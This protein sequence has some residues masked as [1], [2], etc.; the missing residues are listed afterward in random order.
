MPS[1]LAVEINSYT[2]VYPPAWKPA[3]DDWIVGTVLA[4]DLATTKNWGQ[5]TVVRI[6]VEE[7][8]DAKLAG[9]AISL[10]VLHTTLQDEL[11]TKEP[12]VGDRVAIK[13][14]GI[15]PAKDYHRW[16]VVRETPQTEAAPQKERPSDRPTGEED[17]TSRVASPAS[18]RMVSPAA[19]ARA[20]RE[21]PPRWEPPAP[22]RAGVPPVPPRQQS[23]LHL[24]VTDEDIPW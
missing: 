23:L 11:A 9:A 4:F 8:S 19:Q 2:G 20:A 22:F 1:S 14:L 6:Q 17:Q 5:K 16:R 3:P 15:P 18:H 21:N 13:Y 24:L 12:A 7:A 10:W